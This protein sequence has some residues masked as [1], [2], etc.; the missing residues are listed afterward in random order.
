VIHHLRVYLD[1]RNTSAKDRAFPLLGG[2][3]LPC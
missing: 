3:G 1:Q 2:S